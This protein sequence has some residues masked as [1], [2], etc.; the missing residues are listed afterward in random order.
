MPWYN[1]E[2]PTPFDQIPTEGLWFLDGDLLAR[3]Y[4]E[5]WLHG[6]KYPAIHYPSGL[7]RELWDCTY[8]GGIVHIFGALELLRK[9]SFDDGYASATQFAAEHNLKI[10]KIGSDTFAITYPHTGYGYQVHYDLDRNEIVDVRR[11]PDHA[12]E[13]LPSDI[14]AVLPELYKNEHLGLDAIAPVKFFT[15]TSNWTWYPTEYDGEDI[16][17]GLV[18]GLEV[19]L[20]YFSL[21]ELENVRGPLGMPIERDLYYTPTTLRELQHHERR[22][23]G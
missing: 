21:A 19:E 5:E 8:E 13:L 11:I 9:S 15:P 4:R 23:K 14:R 22:L 16:F 18:S 3:L 10:A 1:K 20:G 2:Q 12:A 7:D 6:Q 17:F